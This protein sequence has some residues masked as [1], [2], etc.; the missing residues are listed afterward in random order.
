MIYISR[1]WE[2]GVYRHGRPPEEEEEMDRVCYGVTR[3]YRA[4]CNTN[5]HFSQGRNAE[6]IEKRTV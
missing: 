1:K 3:E 6:N 5:T 4:F 2:Y